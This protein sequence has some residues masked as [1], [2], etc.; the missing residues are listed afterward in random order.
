MHIQSF[1]GNQTFEIFGDN[2][3]INILVSISKLKLVHVVL[4][5][6]LIHQ[7][8]SDLSGRGLNVDLLSKNVPTSYKVFLSES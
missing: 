4:K 5:Q 2:S 1:R 8:H 7:T 3:R 6:T